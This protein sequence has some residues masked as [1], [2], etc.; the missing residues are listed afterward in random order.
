MIIT[1]H[2]ALP[3]MLAERT[4]KE[5]IGAYEVLYGKPSSDVEIILCSSEEAL[6]AEHLRIQGKDDFEDPKVYNGIFLAPDKYADTMIIIIVVKEK[7]VAGAEQYFREKDTGS[8]RDEDMPEKEC[9]KRGVKLMAF[10]GFA[11][12]LQHEYSHLCSFDE[13]MKAT[14][15]RDPGIVKIS[16]D[17]H[18]HDE[19]IAR[20]RGTCACLQMA[21]PLMETDLL[22][23][24]WNMYWE[25]AVK[26]F[27]EEKDAVAAELK[28]I[29]EG[30]MH[31]IR[32]FMDE[33]E[34]SPEEMA[35]ELEYELGHP[36]Q[37]RGEVEA[38]GIPRMNDLET[39]EFVC[40]EETARAAIP[41][42]Y[43]VKNRSATYEGAQLFGLVHAYY[44]FLAGKT[45]AG[46]EALILDP[47][48]LSLPVVIDIPYYDYVSETS[49]GTPP[50]ML[51]VERF[52]RELKG[53][54][55]LF[56]FRKRIEIAVRI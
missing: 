32:A 44:D 31:S 40:V 8:L 55:E 45:G 29:R 48:A 19:F 21:E 37:Y 15:W 54:M 23:S 38:N 34:L 14:G 36:L 20:Y 42:L 2:S 33:E 52:N 22:Y 27:Q 4:I 46:D 12:T 3:D 56:S 50:A 39:V 18:L 16:Q 43:A 6:E 24:L 30:S 11:E 53:I 13:L 26:G 7:T 49:P 35:E 1:N 47:G 41:L 25:G 28:R 51:S 17:Y 9:E 10:F 5:C